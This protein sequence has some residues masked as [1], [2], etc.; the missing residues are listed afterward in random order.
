MPELWWGRMLLQ[1]EGITQ[2]IDKEKKWNLYYFPQ[3]MASFVMFSR[4]QMYHKHVNRYQSRNL[5]QNT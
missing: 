3:W 2:K 5:L 1:D 4:L